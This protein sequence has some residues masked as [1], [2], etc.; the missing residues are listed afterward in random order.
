[1]INGP[2]LSGVKSIRAVH[3]YRRIQL[4][5]LKEMERLLALTEFLIQTWFPHL[6]L[7]LELRIPDSYGT[8]TTENQTPLSHFA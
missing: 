4:C 1:M 8:K 5:S 2:P 6:F 7:D 3:V